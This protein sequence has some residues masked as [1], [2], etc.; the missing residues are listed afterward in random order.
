MEILLAEKER[1]MATAEE[2]ISSLTE[3]LIASQGK[4]RSDYWVVN[5]SLLLGVCLARPGSVGRRKAFAGGESEGVDLAVGGA[6]EIE[7]KTHFLIHPT[8][9]MP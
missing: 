4:V 7:G 8:I 1:E 2:K 3:D 5:R 9:T 6:G